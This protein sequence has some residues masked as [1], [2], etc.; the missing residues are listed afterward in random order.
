MRSRGY[1]AVLLAAVLAL[2]TV[3]TPTAAATTVTATT[4]RTGLGASGLGRGALADADTYLRRQTAE[5]KA[6]GMAYAIV[7]R[8]RIAHI[9]TMGHDGDGEP[10]TAR[11]P[12]LWGSV[13]KPVTA[14]AVMTLVEDGRIDLDRPVRAYLPDFTL[15]DRDTSARITVRHLLLQTSG[16]P[17]VTDST[18]RFGHRPDPYRSAVAE[19]ADVTPLD[20]PGVRHVY[21]SANYL[22]LGA[23]VEA[24]TGRSF[25]SYLRESVLDPLDMTGAIT[26]PAQAA[27]LP[28]GHSYVYG[29]PVATAPRFDQ[30][31]PSYGYLGGTVEDLAHF[32]MAHLNNGTYR[33]VRL[34][35][36]ASVREMHTGTARIRATHH[37]GL[38]WRDDDRN[39]DLGTATLWHGGA[40]PGY[41]ATIVLL[42]GTDRALVVMQN[43]YGYFQASQL[44]ATA[45][46]AARIL[47]GGEPETEAADPMYL[48]LLVSLT[49]VAALVT[50]ATGWGAFRLLRPARRPVSRRRTWS[51]T[52]AW[53]LLGLA[54]A[55]GAWFAAPDA[56]GG[57]QRLIRLYAPD[58]GW[59]LAAITAGGLA[60]A[61][62]RLG[63]GLRAGPAYGPRP[64]RSGP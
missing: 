25:V 64:P 30:T 4:A 3:L 7:D 23:V 27:R 5:M 53:T 33:D 45:L 59:L 17:E 40:A 44:V 52:A 32:A 42:P 11:T 46:G 20:E 31:G 54:L 35:K 43:V 36:P 60:L 51:T 37:Y 22:L 56:L 50:A 39:A 63:C 38:G 9:G 10:V 1:G 55:Y 2:C 24:T 16:L 15:A 19:L 28:D 14:T 49:A 12:F 61:A 13:A 6:P 34:L 26:T 18:D 62:V 48:T 47:A 41:Q 29:R 58:L 21:S 8:R 57:S